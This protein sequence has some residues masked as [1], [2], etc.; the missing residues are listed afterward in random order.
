MNVVAPAAAGAGDIADAGGN[1]TGRIGAGTITGGATTGAGVDEDTIVVAAAAA[2]IGT[3][4]WKIDDVAETKLPES[5]VLTL[6]P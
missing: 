5:L 6:Y 2:G 1:E 3:T 4:T